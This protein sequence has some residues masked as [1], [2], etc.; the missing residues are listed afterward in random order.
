M[1]SIWRRHENC[2]RN[3]GCEANYSRNKESMPQS[4]RVSK[5]Q[6]FHKFMPQRDGSLEK[7]LH[8]PSF[9]GNRQVVSHSY[10]KA[11]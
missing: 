1:P 2:L 3:G 11:A 4:G 5:K 8:C 7:R 10:Q 6:I 9:G